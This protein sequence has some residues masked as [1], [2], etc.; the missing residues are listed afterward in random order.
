MQEVISDAPMTSSAGTC[1]GVWAP[2]GAQDRASRSMRRFGQ[3]ENDGNAMARGIVAGETRAA[4]LIT[5]S[6]VVAQRTLHV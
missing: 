2:I 4:V 1:L 5:E 6:A 3:P